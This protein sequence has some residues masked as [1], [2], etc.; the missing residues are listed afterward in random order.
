M[1]IGKNSVVTFHYRLSE[2]G[3]ELENSHD[4]NPVLSLVG[5]GGLIPGLEKALQGKQKGDTF[6]VS[7]P[8]EDAYGPYVEREPL[9]VPIK[10]FLVF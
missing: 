2:N 1:E 9:R 7:V 5:H 10:K 8:P 3:N 4:G 6:E